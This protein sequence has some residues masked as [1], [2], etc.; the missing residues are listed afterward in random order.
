MNDAAKE[1]NGFGTVHQ[2]LF[3]YVVKYWKKANTIFN[4]LFQMA[5][6]NDD[7]SIASFGRNGWKETI[8]FN[9]KTMYSA[10]KRCSMTKEFD[11][12][13]WKQCSCR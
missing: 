4:L 10:K 2:L 3:R 7:S 8:R 9:Q 12:S 5:Y 1:K 6:E 13:K 11:K